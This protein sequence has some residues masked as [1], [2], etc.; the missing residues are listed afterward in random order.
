METW[1]TTD[2]P[3]GLVAI[4]SSTGGATYDVDLTGFGRGNYHSL[5]DRAFDSIPYF[6]G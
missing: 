6:P 4:R 1:Q 3:L 5:I 2:V